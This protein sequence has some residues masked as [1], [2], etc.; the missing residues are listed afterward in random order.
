MPRAFIGNAVAL[1][2]A[3]LSASI[4]SANIPPSVEPP[5]G[6]A[7]SNTP[8]IVLLT[9][10]DSVTSNSHRLVQGILTNH[11]NPN[12]QPIKATFFVSLDSRIDY[13]LVN[14]L[15]S[16]G[17]EIAIHTM[18]HSTSTNTDLSTWRREIVGCR[19]ALSDFAA[20]PLSDIT[21]FRAP[22]LKFNDD[23]FRILAERGFRY[24]ANLQEWPGSYSTNASSYLWPYTLDGGVVQSNRTG[25][26]PITPIPGLFEIPLWVLVTNG[27]SAVS[28]DPPDSMGSNEVSA[29]W[30]TNFLHHYLGNRAPL[31]LFLHATSTNQWLSNT[32]YPWRSAA[33]NEFID[34][35][36]NYPDVWFI[37]AR[38]LTDF[39]EFPA[40]CTQAFSA[41]MFQT[42]LRSIFPTGQVVRCLYPNGNFYACGTCPAVYPAPTNMYDVATAYSEGNLTFSVNSN[43]F[44]KTEY[45]L[46][47]S[48]TT[49]ESA[50]GWEAVFEFPTNLVFAKGYGGTFSS[51]TNGGMIRLTATPAMYLLPLS[52]NQ[53]ETNVYFTLNGLSATNAVL[54]SS[55]LLRLEPQHPV[56]SDF[57]I[58]ESNTLSMSWNDSAYGY[59]VELSSNLMVD[60]WSSISNVYGPTSCVWSLSS[61]EASNLFFHV[62]GLP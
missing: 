59:S 14:A 40:S 20:I 17:H 9:F 2:I 39:M 34:W 42:P 8:Q 35:T 4:F 60:G 53:V 52:P 46:V 38:D 27:V 7:P 15:Y 21:G 43:L 13:S 5:G 28:M 30:K 50:V 41:A 44:S 18:T 31:G 23:S 1:C 6:L 54:A 47:F 57:T 26:F 37:T 48:N 3:L 29:L 61:S 16:S 32:N 22:Y 56:I 45:H 33:L 55:H 24:D 10:D 58:M 49:Q 36:T 19:K 12:G 11:T 25:A 62:K 51:V